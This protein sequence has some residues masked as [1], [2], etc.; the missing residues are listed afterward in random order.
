MPSS[1]ADGA[2]I[3]LGLCGCGW[4]MVAPRINSLVSPI[5]QNIISPS[6]TPRAIFHVVFTASPDQ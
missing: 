5:P 1:G 4:S 6:T 3:G 2:I